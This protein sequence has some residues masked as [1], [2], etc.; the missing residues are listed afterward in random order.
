MLE[1]LRPQY[2]KR[3]HCIGADCED[4]CCQGWDVVVDQATY[5]RLCASPSLQSR[6]KEHLVVISDP[7]DSKYARIQLTSSRICPFLTTERLCSIQQQHGEYYLPELCA[8]FP[9]VSRSIDGLRETALSL[10]CPEAARLVL[11][12]PELVPQEGG[13]TRYA[14]FARSTEHSSAN[15]SPHQFFWEIRRFTL[16]LIGD[17]TYPLW[18]RL[19]ILGMFCKRL[20]EITAASQLELAAEL[21]KN[22]S[23]IISKGTLRASMDAIPTQASAQ[24]A[25][26][27]EISTRHLSTSSGINARLR[28]CLQDFHQGIRAV[29]GSPIDSFVMFYEEAHARYYAPFMQKH[30]HMMENY[31]LNHVFRTRFPY[32]NDGP[33]VEY[34]R[35]CLLFSVIKGLL[36]G[37]AG[38]YKG[39]FATEHVVKL[40]QTVAKF[41]EQSTKFP[42]NDYMQ[43]ANANGMALLLK[44]NE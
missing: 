8:T 28:E 32:G 4:T 34:L 3:F 21:L 27:L 30:P 7:S 33:I 23:E 14:Y 40:V 26:V 39:G 11:L 5:S 12:D 25:V 19:F 20:H 9:R 1:H 42:Y 24:L 15:I 10:S 35:M 17:R 13:A 37:I 38:H 6:A 44:N 2:A 41:V 31:L 36:I 16:L 22:Y 29:E 18:Q 43:L